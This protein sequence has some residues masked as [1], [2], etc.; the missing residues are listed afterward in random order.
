MLQQREEIE[1]KHKLCLLKVTKILFI[2]D[3]LFNIMN[4]ILNRIKSSYICNVN[5]FKRVSFNSNIKFDKIRKNSTNSNQRND[6][7]GSDRNE[8][9]KNIGNFFLKRLWLLDLS[10][11]FLVLLCNFMIRKGEKFLNLLINWL[12]SLSHRDKFLKIASMIEI[13]II[14]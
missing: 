2:I 14:I 11:L 13:S 3:Y 9:L 7:F 8:R 4:S 10:H 6:D 1:R 5:T 12:L